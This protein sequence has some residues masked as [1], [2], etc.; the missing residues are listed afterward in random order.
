MSPANA[1]MEMQI[2]GQHARSRLILTVLNQTIMQGGDEIV[3]ATRKVKGK[4]RV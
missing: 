4:S 3:V 2:F 1:L